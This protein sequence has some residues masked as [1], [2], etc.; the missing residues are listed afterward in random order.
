MVITE[1]QET[2]ALPSTPRWV[3]NYIYMG[4]RLL[5]TISANGATELVQYHHPD[6]LGTRLV[7]NASDTT[8]FEQAALAFGT[9]LDAESTGTTKRRFTSY[10]RS[11]VTGLDYAVNRHYDPLQG[12]F[13]QV[14]PIKM[15]ASS[16]GDPQSLNMYAYCGNDPV[17]RLDP[18]GLF[19]GWLKALF[20]GI[21][22]VFGFIAKIVKWV[23]FAL[24][25][26]VAVLSIAF[27]GFGAMWALQG[28][29]KLGALWGTVL[30]ASE[31]GGSLTVG[32]VL[33][34]LAGSGVVNDFVAKKK[35]TKKKAPKVPPTPQEVVWTAAYLASLRLDPKSK[36][37]RKACVDLLTAGGVVK[38]ENLLDYYQKRSS[39]GWLNAKPDTDLVEFDGPAVARTYSYG[40]IA[41]SAFGKRFFQN[42]VGNWAHNKTFHNLST[43]RARIMIAFH[44]LGHMTGGTA[45]QHPKDS[46][47]YNEQIYQKCLK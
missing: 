14:D 12:R 36:L 19:W 40:D 23:V 27:I 30:S 31:A 17:N 6:R 42:D 35:E 2:P 10:E 16:L 1:Y 38:P 21:A 5:A 29:I 41:G 22:K 18:S 11:A 15:G 3:K 13:T 45:G 43:Q 33:G 44:E 47:P 8:F 37:Y 39:S 7:T 25:V 28:L 4:S 20:R 24:A 32:K 34:V 26:T 9:A 46:T